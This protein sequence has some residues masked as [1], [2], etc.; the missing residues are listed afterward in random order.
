VSNITITE[1]IDKYLGSLK[2]RRS[3]N[4]L[5]AY[6]N[7]LDT[8]LGMLT[9]QQIDI[10][11]YLIQRLN[12]DSIV[13]FVLYTKKL[14][15]S[16]EGLYLQVIKNFFEF[17]NAEHLA[18]LNI[19][20]V[21]NIIRHRTRRYKGNQA[22]I[23]PEDK[24]ILLLEK[25]SAISDRNDINDKEDKDIALLR[26][27]RDSALILTLA[28]T[29]L[30][31]DEVC[32]IKIGDIDWKEKRTVISGKGKKQDLVRFSARSIDAIRRYLDIRHT[33]DKETGRKLSELPVFA[34]HDK[35]AGK[36][37]KPV[38]TTTIRNIVGER[39]NEFLGLENDHFAQL[40]QSQTRP[41]IGKAQ[42][43]SGHATIRTSQR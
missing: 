21:R 14:S 1:A 28:D 12:E 33:L 42:Q 18:M 24:I 37:I 22:N 8:F 2:S 13:D 29:G 39:V 5:R 26:D 27:M 32:K 16:T 9:S 34:R 38:T 11:T 4:T 17:L 10:T 31:V 23:Y 20:Q 40:R 25:M 30:R 7:A 3:V 15:P 6:T 19:S 36:K 41:G 43:H 35:G